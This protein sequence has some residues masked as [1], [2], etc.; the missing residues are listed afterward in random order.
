MK[1]TVYAVFALSSAPLHQ[2]KLDAQVSKDA[3]LI[4]IPFGRVDLKNRG[5]EIQR[6]GVKGNS[7]FLCFYLQ[8]RPFL[9]DARASS[10]SAYLSG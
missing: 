6:E 9:L 10:L 7:V 1:K 4:A 3:V 5:A 8:R 2:Y